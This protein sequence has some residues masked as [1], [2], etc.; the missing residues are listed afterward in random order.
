[1]L[2]ELPH[3]VTTVLQAR[4]T[5]FTICCPIIVSCSWSIGSN[6]SDLVLSQTWTMFRVASAWPVSSVCFS[7]HFSRLLKGVAGT[8]LDTFKIAVFMQSADW[9]DLPS[10]TRS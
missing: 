7:K 1:M 5:M 2:S 3:P 10:T 4:S 6:V 8:E 9:G